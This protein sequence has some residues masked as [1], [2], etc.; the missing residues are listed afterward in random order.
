[1]SISF[2]NFKKEFYSKF[3][4]FKIFE[5]K[6]FN[7]FKI[8]LEGLK[9]NYYNKGKFST[10]IFY[11][12]YKYYFFY[13]IYRIKKV[14]SGELSRYKSHIEISKKNK[15][16][17]Y[18]LLDS[19]RS[20][21]NLKGEEV[22]IFFSRLFK[23]LKSKH[24]VFY[25]SEN[26]INGYKPFDDVYSDLNS[27]GNSIS[28]K[29]SKEIRIDINKVFQRINNESSF[30]EVDLKNIKC[31][32]QKFYNE[33]VF[34]LNILEYLNPKNILMICHYHKEGLIFAAK[35][36][37]IKI[38][39]YQH[40]LISKSDVFY[41]FPDQIKGIKKDCLFADEIMVYGDH[42]KKIVLEGNSYNLDQ[43]KL[44]TYFQ[45]FRNK[46][47]SF[48]KKLIEEFIGKRKV[49][50]ICSQTYL[51]NYFIIY[52]KRLLKLL[53]YNYCIILK[54][55]PNEN[56]V[57]YELFDINPNI[58]VTNIPIDVIFPYV[59]YHLTIYSSTAFDALRYNLATYYIYVEQCSDYIYDLQ[60]ILGGYVIKDYNEKPWEIKTKLNVQIDNFYKI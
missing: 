52:S 31:A 5:G 16:P 27:L 4:N 34:W 11:S 12:K 7:Y 8:A 37:N 25:A 24:L 46:P 39:E 57:D 42:W 18:F 40:G 30:S 9:V 38:I 32:F 54:P 36:L 59:S 14:L 35:R 6:E 55:H 10:S 26:T 20:I 41:N 45:Y 60:N 2:K 51:T 29:Y 1:M 23:S 43:I 21:K 50:F 58:F 56:F 15:S 17:E 13:Y 19:G 53:D 48:E 44:T 28:H 49:V 33:A 22:P 3:N 47:L